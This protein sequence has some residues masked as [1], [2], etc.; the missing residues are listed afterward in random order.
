MRICFFGD[1]FVNG[2]GDDDGLGWVGGVVARARQGGRNV[3]AYNLGIRRD[4]S[5]DVDARWMREARLRLPLEHDCRL[6]FSF[7]ANDCMAGDGDGSP[8]VKPTDSIANARTILQAARDWLPTLMIGPASV[9]DGAD[10]NERIC[11]LSAEYTGLCESLRHEV[12]PFGIQVAMVEPGAIKTPFYAVPQ[13]EGMADYA[14]WREAALAAMAAFEQAA[15][16]PEVVAERVAKIVAAK[17]PKLRNRI[18]R[19][20]KMFPFLRWLLPAGAFEAGVRRG[21]KLPD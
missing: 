8:Q 14:K 17:H 2:T 11:A 12:K 10:A 4:T 1:S 20:A 19:E 7:G 16:G 15:P 3:T 18:T 9:A 5:A 6:V 21:F 13:S